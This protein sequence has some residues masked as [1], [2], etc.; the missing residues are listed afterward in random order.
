MNWNNLLKNKCPRCSSNLSGDDGFV[1]CDMKWCDFHISE[2]RMQEIVASKVR[3]S[4][5]EQ[6]EK[7]EGYG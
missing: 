3:N 6:D 4:F 2:R 1:S 7:E 5:I